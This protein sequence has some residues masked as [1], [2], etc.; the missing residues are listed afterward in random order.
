MVTTPPAYGIPAEQAIASYNYRDIAEGTGIVDFNAYVGRDDS[1][2]V[3]L[4]TGTLPYSEVIE[5]ST[6]DGGGT[7]SFD[8][9]FILS[10]FKENSS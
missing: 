8:K 7:S 10:G 2:L 6:S 9:T 1:G 4:M 3:Y 5:T